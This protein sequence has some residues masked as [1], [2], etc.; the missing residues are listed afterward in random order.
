[1]TSVALYSSEN[2]FKGFGG[3]PAGAPLGPP[4]AARTE[5][6]TYFYTLQ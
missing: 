1:M 6:C 5:Y 4:L 3:R 2:F